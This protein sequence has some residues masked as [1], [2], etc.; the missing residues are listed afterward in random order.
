[1]AGEE[2]LV[3]VVEEAV[4]QVVRVN[5]VK[6]FFARKHTQIGLTALV[7][8]GLGLV[9]GYK[10]AEKR[11]QTKFDMQLERELESTR[12]W[13]H[14]QGAK[15]NKE[16]IYADP[17]A[18]L[19]VVKK[20]NPDDDPDVPVT[21]K[22]DYKAM[23]DPESATDGDEQNEFLQG[24][25]ATVTEISEEAHVVQKK[26]FVE[27]SPETDEY[28]AT[29]TE[30]LIAAGL[31]YV[32]S[33]DDFNENETEFEQVTI[34]WFAGDGVLADEREQMI[35]D[36]EGIVGA[37]NMDRFGYLSNDNNIVYVRNP[38]KELEFE[39]VHSDG[40]YAQ[41]VLGFEHSDETFERR[42]RRSRI[43]DDG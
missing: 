3:E 8:V 13:L 42:P 17:E 15:V 43:G 38:D 21:M 40:N 9:T 14:D 33:A 11:L 30:A 6:A 39:V 31:P 29:A 4:D 35:E 12:E 18:L 32:I 27:P 37:S 22:T 10:V 26:L 41:E 23:F 28:H 19:E 36:V 16:G 24:P 2:T 34:T 1:M 7:G 20:E 5:V 25:P